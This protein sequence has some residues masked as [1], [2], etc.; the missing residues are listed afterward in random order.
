[1]NFG[2]YYFDAI[3]YAVYIALLPLKCSALALYK[4]SDFLFVIV[5]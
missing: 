3:I 4:L 5:L 1:M 2:T